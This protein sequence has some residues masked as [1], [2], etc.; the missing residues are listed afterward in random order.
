MED[1]SFTG[2][3]QLAADSQ[4]HKLE[5]LGMEVKRSADHISTL[6]HSLE[7]YNRLI[8]FSRSTTKRLQCEVEEA[9]RTL[10]LA[11]SAAQ[12]ARDAEVA[13]C[14][15][16]SVVSDKKRRAEEEDAKLRIRHDSVKAEYMLWDSLSHGTV[17]DYPPPPLAKVR[18][19]LLLGTL[20]S[21]RMSLCLLCR[22]PLARSRPSR[23]CL[24]LLP[25]DL[26]MRVRG[27]HAAQVWMMCTFLNFP[28]NA[29]MIYC[30]FHIAGRE[31][32]SRRH[33]GVARGEP[34]RGYNSRGGTYSFSTHT[35]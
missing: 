3:S 29:K 20:Q 8:D 33:D 34:W 30:P 16:A 11:K 13:H 14:R 7:G 26:T 21:L 25:V 28:S 1:A 2:A 23:S 32:F 10:S 31:P 22:N 5:R 19:R 4:L 27:C 24:L 9:E 15:A 12:N 35:V 18:V 6:Q 17:H